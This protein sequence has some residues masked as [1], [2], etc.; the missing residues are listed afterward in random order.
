MSASALP[1]AI[2]TRFG[3]RSEICSSFPGSQQPESPTFESL[4]SEMAFG[5]PSA[6]VNSQSVFQT[7]A[8]ERPP[9]TRALGMM[10]LG[11][12]PCSVC[13]SSIPAPSHSSAGTWPSGGPSSE[14]LRYGPSPPGVKT[15]IMQK[16]CSGGDA[17]YIRYHPRALPSIIRR[18]AGARGSHGG[19]D[20]QEGTEF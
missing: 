14:P 17:V 3:P 10:E 15:F 20:L 16:L 11:P 6:P 18:V 2:P 4:I 1:R 19:G 9:W 8:A 7:L 13:S 12:P 5:L